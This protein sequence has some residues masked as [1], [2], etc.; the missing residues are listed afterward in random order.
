MTED[1]E[2]LEVVFGVAMETAADFGD[3]YLDY[4]SSEYE[5]LKKLFLN[6][7]T[8]DM[9]TIYRN[10]IS[11]DEEKDIVRLQW[12]WDEKQKEYTFVESEPVDLDFQKLTLSELL[13]TSDLNE[14]KN[15]ISYWIIRGYWILYRNT[16][17]PSWMK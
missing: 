4:E 1:K 11:E 5:N 8:A 12:I 3:E 17:Y 13:K 9:F 10:E 6:N 7:F 16:Y 14:L 2:Y 15:F